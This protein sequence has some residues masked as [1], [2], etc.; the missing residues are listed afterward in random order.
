MN[1]KQNEKLIY[2][3][4]RPNSAFHSYGPRWEHEN[5][6]PDLL[7]LKM[8]LLACDFCIYSTLILVTKITKLWTMFYRFRIYYFG[9]I[10][11]ALHTKIK[12][13]CARLWSKSN[14]NNFDLNFY[15]CSLCNG[16][17]VFII[18]VFVRVLKY[19]R[20]I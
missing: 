5:K 3:F 7:Q 13:M 10:L 1:N 4:N 20:T 9:F 11:I 15:S 17:N 2:S 12:G 19:R 6:Y 16:C 18:F 8:V 14:L